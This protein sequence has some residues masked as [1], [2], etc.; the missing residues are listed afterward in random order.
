MSHDES[1]NTDPNALPCGA[2]R[3][4]EPISGKLEAGALVF[5]HNHGD[6]GPGV[7]P[8]EAWRHNKA[9]FSKTGVLLPSEGWERTLSPL[10]PEGFYLVTEDFDC[11]ENHCR[12]FAEGTLVQLGYNRQAEPLLFVPVWTYRGLQ[13]PERG[14]KVEEARLGLLRRLTLV[15]RF[16]RKDLAPGPVFVDQ[17]G[18]GYLQ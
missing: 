16:D 11:C 5:Y 1:Q 18:G 10:Q 4:T 2:Y 6:P 13:L 12:T 9:V 15:E 7:Y 3:T 14:T 17:A 8:A